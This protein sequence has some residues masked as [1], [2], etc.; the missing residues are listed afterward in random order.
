MKNWIKQR[1]KKSLDEVS[2]RKK[3]VFGSG[4]QHTV[5]K[6]IKHQDRLYKVGLEDDV[7]FW[8]YIFKENPK[9]FPKVYRVFQ[10]KT[11]PDYWIVE[12]EKLNTESAKEDFNMVNNLLRGYMLSKNNNSPIQIVTITLAK[13]Y[14]I[15][16]TN[17][18]FITFITNFNKYL[19]ELRIS[20]NDRKKALKW[21]KMIYY[22]YKYLERKYD[23][24]DK[25]LHSGNVAYDNSGNIK[26]ID[27]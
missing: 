26:I 13:I 14:K 12:I 7:Q 20:D 6:S 1:L 23:Y 19:L 4:V 17:T 10:S 15:D 21:V 16:K 18:D 9:I 8:T 3:P 2:I 24:F 25:D 22:V 27:I 5:L 11:D